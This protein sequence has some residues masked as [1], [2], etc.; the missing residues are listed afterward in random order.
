MTIS[1]LHAVNPGRI[2][3]QARLQVTI[4]TGA[5][6]CSMAEPANNFC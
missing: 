2:I 5:G 1:D 3:L 4:P 6:A